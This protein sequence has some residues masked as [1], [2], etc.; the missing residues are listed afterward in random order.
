MDKKTP[1]V[2]AMNKTQLADQYKVSRNILAAWLKPIHTQ[3][4]WRRGKQTFTPAQVQLIY[5]L[6]DAPEP[7]STH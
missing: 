3:I 1:A 7:D 4:G 5:N 6:L 2:V